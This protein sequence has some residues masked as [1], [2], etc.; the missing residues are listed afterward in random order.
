MHIKM[1]D[2]KSTIEWTLL[3][4]NA[5]KVYA[6]QVDKTGSYR[7][8]FGST[9]QAGTWILAQ[10]DWARSEMGFTFVNLS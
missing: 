10:V 1:T 6:R 4:T 5:T 8:P 2:G 9:H 7:L 3:G